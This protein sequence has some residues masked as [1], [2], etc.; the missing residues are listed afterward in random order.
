MSRRATHTLP[1]PPDAVLARLRGMANADNVAGMRRFGI[2]GGEML[3]ISVTTLRGIGNEIG[4]DHALALQLWDT[5]N[6]EARML[7]TIVDDPAKV[8]RSQMERWVKQI[9]SWDICDGACFGLFD[10]TPHAY[11]RA[12]EWSSRKPEF[13]KRAGFVVMAGMAVHDKRAADDVFLSFLPVIAREAYDERNFVKKGV[14][15][16]LRQIGKRNLALNAAAIATA[17]EIRAAGTRAGRWIAA[18]ALREL[19]S[20]AKQKRLRERD[21]R[22]ASP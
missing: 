19:T 12:M 6:H 16:A 11:D 2:S 14:N 1:P 13:Q 8:T 7:A 20:E 17:E 22:A 9:D 5:G 3:G 15:W 18:D 21:H 4:R 10:R